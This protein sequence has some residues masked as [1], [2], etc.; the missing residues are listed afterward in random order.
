MG[1]AWATLDLVNNRKQ[2][3]EKRMSPQRTG[4][5]TQILYLPDRLKG[6]RIFSH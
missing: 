1:A 6:L 3:E 5:Q 2:G 4:F